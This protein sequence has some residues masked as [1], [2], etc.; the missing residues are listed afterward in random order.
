LALSALELRDQRAKA[1]DA[2]KK[3][4][5][6]KRSTN[7]MM[8]AEDTATYE[9]MEADVANL[10]KQIDIL[11][12]QAAVD[13]ALSAA[14][15]QPIVNAPGVGNKQKTGRATDEYRDAFWNAMRNR[16]TPEV[17]NA[18]SI[19]VDEDGGHLVP[20][21]YERT[22]I[23]ALEEENIMRTIARRITTAHGERKIPIVTSKGEAAWVEEN[24]T[25]P[26][27]DSKFDSITLGAYKAATAIRVSVELINDSVFDIAAY[28]AEEFGRRMGAIEEEAFING[29]GVSQPTGLLHATKGVASG[30]VTASTTKIE[31]DEVMD[32]FYSVRAPY[33]RKA[34]F[35]VHDSTMKQLRKLKDNAGQYLWQ[36]SVKDGTPDTILS[37]P[38]RTSVY[39]PVVEAA[40]KPML[41]GDFS[42]YWI[43]DRQGRVFQRLNELYATSGQVGFLAYQRVDGKLIL[44]EAIKALEI[45]A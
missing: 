9:K 35:L 43:A 19:G 45:K 36:P 37:K 22:L 38:I 7:G 28:V 2:A 21:E 31:M 44:P 32:L 23:K 20:D 24:G 26:E 30:I 27:S 18:L 6:E 3:F 8:N 5:D 17:V 10:T 29:T 16:V 14:T 42:Y 12:R 41:F 4:L 13:A 33:R 15:S 1:W 11:D 39:M 34:S 25:I 40:A